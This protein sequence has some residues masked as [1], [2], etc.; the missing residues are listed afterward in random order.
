MRIKHSETETDQH[1]HHSPSCDTVIHTAYKRQ[2]RTI[3]DVECR[4]ANLED[5]SGGHL[6]QKICEVIKPS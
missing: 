4:I 5:H 1:H 6:S 2:C 3:K